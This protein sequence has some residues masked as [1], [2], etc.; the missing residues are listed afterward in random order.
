M[1]A[2]ENKKLIQSMFAE[3]SRGNGAGYLDGLA[4]D[5]QFTIMGSTKYSGTFRGKQDVINRLLN[6]LMSELD[7]GLE[8][9]PDAF[10]AEGDT[11]VM[12]GHG[13]SKTKSGKPYNNLYC[14]VFRIA[15]G[16]VREITEYLDTELVTQA[17]G[18]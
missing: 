15:G 9:T 17:F 18:K 1:G 8:V 11:V 2:A 5:V 6:P 7:G 13:R 16:K 4:D 10:I 3:L 14:Q 12:Q